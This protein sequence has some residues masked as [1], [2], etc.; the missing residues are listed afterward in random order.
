MLNAKMPNL[1]LIPLRQN[2]LKLVWYTRLCN[3]SNLSEAEKR[4]LQKKLSSS[5]LPCKPMLTANLSNSK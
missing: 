4:R 2:M 3:V 1:A 5:R